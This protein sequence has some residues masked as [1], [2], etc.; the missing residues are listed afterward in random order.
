MSKWLSKTKYCTLCFYSSSL[1]SKWTQATSLLHNICRLP[2]TCQASVNA[3]S[4]FVQI[5]TVTSALCLNEK[6][7]G[8]NVE[9]THPPPP[10]RPL[11]QLN[12]STRAASQLLAS[13]GQQANIRGGPLGHCMIRVSRVLVLFVGMSFASTETKQKCHLWQHHQMAAIYSSVMYQSTS[14][15]YW[16]LDDISTS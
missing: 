1:I 9:M 14:L 5:T 2:H 4:M 11:Q 15:E 7:R 13:R 12:I 10:P 8:Q 3:D 16:H 6:G